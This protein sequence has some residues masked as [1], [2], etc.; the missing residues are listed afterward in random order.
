MLPLPLPAFD[1]QPVCVRRPA[2]LDAKKLQ[3]L[4]KLHRLPKEIKAQLEVSL[5]SKQPHKQQKQGV[6]KPQP[7]TSGCQKNKRKKKPVLESESSSDKDTI[8]LSS[9]CS[10]CSST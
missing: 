3:K 1:G 7:S 8:S 2:A 9:E 10:D 5:S 4:A 6:P